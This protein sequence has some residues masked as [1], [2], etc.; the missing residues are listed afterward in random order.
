MALDAIGSPDLE[1]FSARLLGMMDALTSSER[2]VART[3]LADYPMAA[4]DSVASLASKAGVSPPTVLRFATKVGF[5]GWPEFQS[6]LRE[7]VSKRL[8]SPLSLYDQMKAVPRHDDDDHA[9]NVFLDALA[10]TFSRLKESVIDDAVEMLTDPKARVYVIGGRFSS[11]LGGYFATHLQM[12]RSGVTSVSELPIHRTNALL[13][14]SRN[15]VLVAV[16]FR[17]YQRD[18]IDFGRAAAERGVR[19][20]LVTDPWLSP[21]VS[22]ARLVLGAET[23]SPSP[24]DSFVSAIGVLEYLIYRMAE[25]IGPESLERMRAHDSLNHSLMLGEDEP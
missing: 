23:T 8:A 6:V 7:E 12:L 1:P 18:T 20:I 19:L 2:Q 22:D 11:A 5:S 17:R 25:S 21:L 14:M 10:T 15:D 24:F 3:I 4:L 9:A 16:D 13:E